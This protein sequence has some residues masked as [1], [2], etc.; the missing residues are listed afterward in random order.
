VTN[1]LKVSTE[2]AA[3]TILSLAI[4]A[5]VMQLWRADLRVPFT[6]TGDALLYGIATKGAIEE[7]WWLHNSSLGAPTGLKYEAY[8]A[9]ENFHFLLIKLISIFSSDYALTLNLYYLLTF[10]L[11]AITSLY[12][13]KYF[14]FSFGSALFGSL[15][16][17][18]L[19]YHFFRS[20]HLFLAAY[21]MV[22]LMILVILWVCSGKP[23][24]VQFGDNKRWP[25]L[26]FKSY[27]SVFSI[28]VC[29]IVGSCGLYYP[30]FSC[31]LLLIAG[32]NT[33]V[34]RKKIAA[35][36]APAILVGILAGTVFINHLP[37][38][39]Y[40]YT[41][42]S[43]GL[44]QRSV[45]DAEVMGFKITQLLLPIGGHRWM[46]LRALKYRYNLGP[47]V[48]ENDTA[49]LGFVG[50]IGFLILLG[51]LFSRKV[52]RSLI[53]D[54]SLLNLSALLL[55][56]IGGFGVLFAIFISPQIR[57]YNRISVFIAFFSL[58][59]VTQIVEVLYKTLKRRGPKFYFAC[60]GALIVVVGILDQTSD[61]HFFVPEYERIKT[62]YQADADFINQLEAT[63]PPRSMVFQ[64]PYIPFPESPGAYK[65][66]DHEPLKAYLHS[67]SLRWSYGAIAG[68]EDDIWQRSVAAKPT[69]EF[70]QDI[71]RAGFKGIYLNRDGYADNGAA[72][73]ADL[74]TIVGTK[75]IVNRRRN[76]V[77][78]NLRN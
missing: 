38:A 13:F 70:V 77:F 19:P 46:P 7:G 12:F 36:L 2:Y 56:T 61:I 23:F 30:F 52:N 40:Q 62:E 27:E 58:V 34:Q 53:D 24:L 11:T 60:I 68:Q 17:T 33:C 43:S 15:L 1:K 29:V 3:A 65:L 6:Y 72:I 59:A 71:S 78:Y 39:I 73:E 55:A 41:H 28:V 45:V 69:A 44:G 10:P 14:K 48:N 18:F 42:G 26:E 37:L 49:S 64:L 5:C 76:L 50:S 8:P 31:F 47:L 21:Y 51:R 66:N 57:A 25:R 9:I 22:P 35:L 75:P 16:F 4:L 67:K 32:A 63:L 54:L 20:Y 74:R